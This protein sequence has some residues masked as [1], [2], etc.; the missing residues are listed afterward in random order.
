M[1]RIIFGLI[2]ILSITTTNAG[3]VIFGSG[4]GQ[5]KINDTLTVD[6]YQVQALYRFNSGIMV[7]GMIQHG[8]PK[9]NAVPN[10]AREEVIVG[11]G[12]RAYNFLPY[13]FI[14]I[15]E[16][17]RDSV[18][19]YNYHTLRI[20]SKYAINDHFYLD[21]SYRFRDTDKADWKTDTYF[22]GI[23]YNINTATSVQFQYG[24]TNGSFNS[25]SYGVFLVN[26]F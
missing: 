3:N 22:A 16:R 7:G 14:S 20:G 4:Y 12:T 25:D 11:Y 24:K 10:E 8:N 5:E 15:G 1:K 23:G 13:A 21:A 2:L 26:R 9:N 18:S 19:E 6:L 17:D